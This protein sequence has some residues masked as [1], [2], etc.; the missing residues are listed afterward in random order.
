MTG[1][2]ILWWLGKGVSMMNYDIPRRVT[3]YIAKKEGSASRF[4]L[5]NNPEVIQYLF[6]NTSFLNLDTTTTTTTKGTTKDQVIRQ[7]KTREDEWG[8]MTMK[9]RRPDLRLD[10]QWTNKFGEHVTEEIL[11]LLNAKE[12]TKPVKKQHF[13]PDLETEDAIYEVKTQTYFTTGTAGEKILG[14]PFKYA[15]IPVL[16]GKPLK[17]VCIGGAELLC[18]NLYGNLP[19][20]KCTPQKQKFIDFFRDNRIEFVAASDLLLQ[21]LSHHNTSTSSDECR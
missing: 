17:I 12:V 3:E 14:C 19:G 5:L 10:K 15:E 11:S 16:Y 13:Q 18:K 4:R 1:K 7:T 2:L 20:D 21:A 9:E 8:Q 6:H